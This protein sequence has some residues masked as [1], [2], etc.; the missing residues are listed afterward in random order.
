MSNIHRRSQ[1]QRRPLPPPGAYYPLRERKAPPHERNLHDRV[2]DLSSLP[3][4]PNAVCLQHR[5]QTETSASSETASTLGETLSLSSSS[6]TLLTPNSI[7]SG[8]NGS[9]STSTATTTATPS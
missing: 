7:S 1:P 3:S 6:H 5:S 4:K 2:S 8:T 9:N